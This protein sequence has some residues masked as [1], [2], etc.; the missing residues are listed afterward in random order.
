MPTLVVGMSGHSLAFNNSCIQILT[1]A[2][3]IKNNFDRAIQSS[4]LEECKYYTYIAEKLVLYLHANN[5]NCDCTKNNIIKFFTYTEKSEN[6]SSL[7][8]CKT[9]IDLS[10]QFLN[11]IVSDISNCKTS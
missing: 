5:D 9:N 3:D 1:K 2:P 8:E 10:I 6:V 4:T 11:N 7:K